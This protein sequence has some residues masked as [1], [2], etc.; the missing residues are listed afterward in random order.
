MGGFESGVLGN[1]E[2][3]ASGVN[4]TSN[5]DAL[6]SL[7]GMGYDPRLAGMASQVYQGDIAT[8]KG[9]AAQEVTQRGQAEANRTGSMEGYLKA[10]EQGKKNIASVY[11]DA[12][13]SITTKQTEAQDAIDKR[14]QDT[15]ALIAKFAKQDKDTP[16]VAGDRAVEA[17][18]KIDLNKGGEKVAI[19]AIK[20]AVSKGMGKD[21]VRKMIDAYVAKIKAWKPT[22]YKTVTPQEVARYNGFEY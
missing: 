21:A 16:G 15:I 14:Q 17:F 12:S 9:E 11:D 18:N 3:L 4:S 19:D 5:I 8:A 13:R 1:Q 7:L 20:S 22:Q 2:A 6:R 10:V